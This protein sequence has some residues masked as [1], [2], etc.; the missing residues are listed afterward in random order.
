[1]LGVVNAG[2][3]LPMLGLSL[4]GGAFADRFNRKRLIQ[5]GQVV[6]AILA[7]IVGIS[8]V[9]GAVTWH[10]LLITSMI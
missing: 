7:L 9:T 5:F 1:M 3:A 4:F 8:I 10:Y 2:N 6:F